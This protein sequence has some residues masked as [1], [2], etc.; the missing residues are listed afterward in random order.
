MRKALSRTLESHGYRV[1]QAING[2]E[3]SLLCR[4]HEGPIDLLLSDIALP[5]L[6]GPDLARIVTNV[7]PFTRILFLTAE[8]EEANVGAGLCPACWLLIR[9]PFR[10][11]ELAV[12]L[13]D[14]LSRQMFQPLSVE[15]LTQA[16]LVERP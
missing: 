15:A 5:G 4:H 10:P 2:K 16:G 8:L 1:L 13:E 7:R 14:F 6:R 3:A 11:K 9:K 12:A